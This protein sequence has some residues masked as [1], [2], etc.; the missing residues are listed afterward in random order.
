MNTIMNIRNLLAIT[1]CIF[2]TMVCKAQQTFNELELLTVNEQVTTV[3]TATEPI[4]FVDISTDKIAG[5]Q[6]LGNTIR[7]KP[8]E[9]ADVNEDG[10]IL[11][12]VTIVTIAMTATTTTTAGS[13]SARASSA[14]SVPSSSTP[15]RHHSS[16]PPPS[17]SS[18]SASCQAASPLPSR[19]SVRRPARPP[20]PPSS[21]LSNRFS[22]RLQAGFCGAKPCFPFRYSAAPSFSPP[23][24][25]LLF[26]L[27]WQLL[28][29]VLR[30]RNSVPGCISCWDHLQVPLC[31]A[32]IRFLWGC[33][34]W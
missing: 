30:G 19:P 31:W 5:D 24:S 10:D 13:N 25:S 23:S 34:F 21:C 4:R 14:A 17:P 20:S 1:L 32:C 2:S 3:I 15:F 29:I 8:K 6:P 27:F 33:C 22:A 18:T 16:P 26:P 28:S 12:I 7:L 9:G 11:A